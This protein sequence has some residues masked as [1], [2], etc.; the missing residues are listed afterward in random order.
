MWVRAC[1]E[2]SSHEVPG[3]GE[4]VLSQVS[5]PGGSLED[6]IECVL[7]AFLRGARHLESL[8]QVLRRRAL[9]ERR[10]ERADGGGAGIAEPSF[11]EEVEN[12]IAAGTY[13]ESFLQAYHGQT[14][15]I[16]SDEIVP[17]HV[18]RLAL[19]VHSGGAYWSNI[20]VQDMDAVRHKVETVGASSPAEGS[21][22]VVAHFGAGQ[23]GAVFVWRWEHLLDEGAYNMPDWLARV[24]KAEGNDPLR[25]LQGELEAVRRW[26]Q[27]VRSETAQ[28]V[29]KGKE[30]KDPY[31]REVLRLWPTESDP[32]GGHNL[33]KCAW[34]E[35]LDPN[36]FIGR[37]VPVDRVPYDADHALALHTSIAR[38]HVE[39]PTTEK[40]PP[41]RLTTSWN[42]TSAAATAGS[43]KV[44]SARSAPRQLQE[45]VSRSSSNA[46]RDLSRPQS[47]S[48]PEA[49]PPQRPRST[50]GSPSSAI[51]CPGAGSGQ[52][53]SELPLPPPGTQLGSD[54]PDFG[55]A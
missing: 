25:K 1:P 44:L 40:S 22:S 52:K 8:Q 3:L 54:F 30:I 38:R 36:L 46:A 33:K 39:E 35:G 27:Q 7:E 15:P 28:Y 16:H 9:E 42:W 50:A 14:F 32:Q 6:K 5:A 21:A 2:L 12:V 24:L 55:G 26:E 11:P 19:E 10:R 37:T 53:S 29:K 18:Y 4:E 34:V 41:Y 31:I 17:G 48:G 51:P 47:G 43:T 45:P 49:F 20:P 13:L 23:R